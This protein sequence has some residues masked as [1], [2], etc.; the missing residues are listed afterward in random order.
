MQYAAESPGLLHKKLSEARGNATGSRSLQPVRQLSLK[1][2]VCLTAAVSTQ[3]SK[4]V[5]AAIT[6]TRNLYFRNLHEKLCKI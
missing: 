4:H 3:T 2:V 6:V 5:T 1:V